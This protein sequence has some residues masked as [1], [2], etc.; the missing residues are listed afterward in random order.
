VPFSSRLPRDLSPNSWARLRT[1]RGEDILDLT[2]GNPT[3]CGIP[4]PPDLL[5][6]L[7]RPEGLTYRPDP[8][9][10]EAAR[11]AVARD[12]ARRGA[13]VDPGAVVLTASTSEAYALLLKLLCDPGDAV[14]VPRPSYPLFDHLCRLEA[15]RPVAYPLDPAD[16]WQPRL[17]GAG[18]SRARALI[19]VHPNNPTGSYLEPRV[20]GDLME[21]C[22]RLGAALIVDEVFLDYGLA[23]GSGAASLA[24]ASRVL[25]F[26]LGGLS[27]SVGLPQVKVAWIVVSGPAREAREARER[28]EFIADQYLSAST[29]AQLALGELLA[30]GGAVRAAILDRCRENLRFLEGAI[31]GVPAVSLPR[32]GGGWSA[33]LRFPGM[34]DE[35]S[36]ALELLEHDGVAVH[37]GYF[38][39]FPGEGYLVV[40]LLPEPDR[41]ARGAGRV[42]A[43]IASH[44]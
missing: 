32:P 23:P 2:T 7:G 3:T 10:L 1:E 17:P 28:L 26:A 18:V 19:A 16:G 42:L 39:D 35:E 24:G 38:F 44:L 25:T 22:A 13:V 43:R 14:L 27:K 6:R 29:P 40:S 11:L 12:Y 8:R 33:V 4:Y 15:A 36:L 21:H 30:R 34:V 9:G 5:V 41:F 31:A 37:P 20:C